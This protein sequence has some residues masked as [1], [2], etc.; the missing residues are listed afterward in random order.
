M[1]AFEPERTCQEM[2]Q[3]C[4]NFAYIAKLRLID[5]KIIV[6]AGS[7]RLHLPAKSVG[8]FIQS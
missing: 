2:Q 5:L 7:G 8:T 4:A 6:L 3:A 1:I